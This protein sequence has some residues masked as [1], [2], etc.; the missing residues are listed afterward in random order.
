M[1]AA[2]LASK[3]ERQLIRYIMFWGKLAKSSETKK[4]N[5]TEE[6]NKYS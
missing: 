5:N 2:P 6:A 1:L 3:R 4:T